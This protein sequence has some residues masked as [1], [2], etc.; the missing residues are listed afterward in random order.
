MLLLPSMLTLAAGCATSSGGGGGAAVPS[1]APSARTASGA[2]S[3]VAPA[4]ASSPAFRDGPLVTWGPVPPG[5]SH[6]ERVRTYDLQHQ[7]VKVSFDWRRHAVVGET[8]L[9]IAALDSAL[10]VVALDAVG[11][12][13][14]A[15]SDARSGA[16]LRHD[17]DGRVLVVHLASPLAPRATAAVTVRYEAVRPQKGAYFV[18]RRHVVWTQGETEDTRYWIPTYDYPNDRT[19]W[20]FF[21]RVSKREKALSNGYLDDTRP[22]GADSVEWHW[23]QSRPA[24]TYLM[25]VVTGDYVI[26]QDKWKDTPVA[27]WTYPDSVRAAWRGFGK[28][29]RAIDLFSK[30]T[31]VDYPWPKYD[32]SVVPDFIFGGEENVTATT[33]ADDDILHPAWAEPQANADD[34]VSHEL[35]HQWYGDLLTTRD[36]AN[37]WLNEGFATFMEQIF[38][39]ADKGR[40]EGAFYRLGAQEETIAADERARRPLVFDRWVTDPLELFFSGHIYPK[41]AT[42]LQMMRHQLGDSLFW[43]AMHRYTVD[44]AAGNVVSADLE[45]AFEQTTGRDYAPFFRQWVYG[46]GFPAFRVRY[47]YDAASR[48]LTLTAEQVQARDSLTGLFDADVDVE[49]LTSAGAVTAKVPVRGAAT[50]SATT[51]FVMTLPALPL[52]I[53]WDKGGWLLDVTDFP[54]PTAML[55]YQRAHDDDV[56]GRIE[57]IAPLRDRARGDSAA[58]RALLAATTDAFWAVR[59]RAVVAIGTLADSVP[60]DSAGAGALQLAE[61]ARALLAAASDSD[62]RVRET[63]ADALGATAFAGAADVGARL[64]ELAATDS[65]RFVRAAAVVAY[66]AIAPDSALAVVREMARRDSWND[67]ERAAALRAAGRIDRPESVALLRGYLGAAVSR[68]AR[69]AA[70]AALL[71]RAGGREAEVAAA[72]VPLL[73]ADDLFIR[74]AAADALGRLGQRASVSALQ[75]RRRVEAESRVLNAID[76]AL[77]ALGGGAGQ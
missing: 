21:V 63:A 59:Q 68:P 19:T 22:I 38:H 20:E 53:R 56:L 57:A 61:L 58:M 45:R 17:Y 70:I 46:A 13:V 12:N 69:T 6:A 40:D 65:S 26:L 1:A 16:V 24:S 10:A 67:V 18:D 4:A 29:P 74:Q 51:R 9:R 34:L 33:Q 49:V 42:V 25:S 44:H 64:R 31:G 14:V 35:G 48:Q 39:E 2:A 8:T 76:T 66:A 32:Q 60:A 43:R 7:I 72:I 77:R 55:A 62:S 41:G 36:W 54:R 75:T 52:S 73:D 30:R 27:Y 28:T 23:V 47:S 50:G 11:M 37:V 5:A 15:V 3:T 71:E